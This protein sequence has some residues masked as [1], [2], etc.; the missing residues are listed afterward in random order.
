MNLPTSPPT[1]DSV[2]GDVIHRYTRAEAIE[3]GVLHDTTDLA[4]E[5]GF[6]VP[7]AITARVH[8]ECVTIPPAAAGTGQDER[9][10]LWDVLWMASNA[11]RRAASA[12]EDSVTFRVTVRNR[13]TVNYRRD[14][15]TLRAVIGPG[16][17]GEPVITILFPD[18]D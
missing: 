15:V 13:Q 8:A 4:R 11:C 18:E 2:F 6:T 12:G 5:A 7:T 10:R 16:D 1:A 3:D 14:T 17:Q 9:G